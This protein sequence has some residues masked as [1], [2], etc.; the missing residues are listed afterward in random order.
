[1][2]RD[3]K[4]LA[5][6]AYAAGLNGDLDTAEEIINAIVRHGPG[7]LNRAMV[8]WVDRTMNIL[9]MTPGVVRGFNLEADGTGDRS[10]LDQISPEVVWAARMFTARAARDR[11]TWR[12]L[13]QALPRDADAILRHVM[14]L[15]T[16]MTV[17]VI[18]DREDTVDL[19]GPCAPR[20]GA[21]QADARRSVAHL[22]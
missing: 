7:S 9:G 5:N 4:D 3:V 11:D 17:T 19:G 22:N 12:A 14:A 20:D 15:L 18:A 21:Y 10:D 6:D 2:K 16:T 1:M 8:V 13:R